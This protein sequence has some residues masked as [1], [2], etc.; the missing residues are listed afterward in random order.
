MS[1]LPEENIFFESSWAPK[2]GK[3]SCFGQPFPYVSATG[4]LG[5][6]G[7][8]VAVVEGTAD[9]DGLKGSDESISKRFEQEVDI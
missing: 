9:A 7:G 1:L 2:A 4:R 5:N 6:T 8:E 3:G